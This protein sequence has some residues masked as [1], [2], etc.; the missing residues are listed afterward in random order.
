M[1][2]GSFFYIVAA[3]RE[4]RFL[5]LSMFIENLVSKATAL[6]LRKKIAT[7]FRITQTNFADDCSF[8]SNVPLFLH[9]D[10]DRAISEIPL[11]R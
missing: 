9:I 2:I 5:G 10:D 8:S 6:E 7:L 11:F 3:L 4:A 1:E